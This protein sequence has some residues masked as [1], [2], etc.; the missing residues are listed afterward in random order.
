MLPFRRHRF[1]YFQNKVIAT[2]LSTIPNRQG[3][4]APLATK[5]LSGS[6]HYL[7]LMNPRRTATTSLLASSRMINSPPAIPSLPDHAAERYPRHVN[8]YRL[9]KD[10]NHIPFSLFMERASNPK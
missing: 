4:L 8:P 5:Y 10:L 1:N 7:L 2:M 6:S 9:L 3:K